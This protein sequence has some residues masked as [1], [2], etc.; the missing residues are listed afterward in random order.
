MNNLT[1][2]VFI[3]LEKPN[4]LGEGGGKFILWSIYLYNWADWSTK[5]IGQVWSFLPKD[6]QWEPKKIV[7]EKFTMTCAA[8][9]YN[10]I[11]LHKYFN[12]LFIE[13]CEEQTMHKE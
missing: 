10:R 4:L 13:I 9:R 1:S 8:R 6:F 11:S 2:Y 3:V 5:A 7:L 12:I